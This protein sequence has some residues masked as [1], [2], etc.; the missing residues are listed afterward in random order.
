M[1]SE[2]PTAKK[3]M[4]KPGARLLLVNAPPGYAESLGPLPSGVTVR[5]SGGGEADAIQLFV[6]S[7]KE[8]ESSLPR[9][10]AGL[11]P[12]GMIWLT[13]P[14]GTSRAK[15]DINRDSIREYAKTIGLEAVAIFSL[16]DDWSALRLNP[17]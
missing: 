1:P 17:A 16:D 4:L 14:K 2:R 5:T 12:G 10:K 8:L 15:A 13:Y 7:R 11:G 3:L 9:L 6:R